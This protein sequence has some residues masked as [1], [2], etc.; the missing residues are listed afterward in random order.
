MSDPP[1]CP[2][3]KIE[4]NALFAA[5]EKLVGLSGAPRPVW[6]LYAY[7]FRALLCK[8]LCSQRACNILTKIQDAHAVQRQVNYAKSM[9]FGRREL[10]S[11]LGQRGQSRLKIDVSQFAGIRGFKRL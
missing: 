1:V 2:R 11:K 8:Q 5:V 10:Q 4:N 9:A 3:F 7:D 6:H